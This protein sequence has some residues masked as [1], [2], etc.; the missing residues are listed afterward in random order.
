MTLPEFPTTLDE[1]EVLASR[2]VGVVTAVVS[3]NQDPDGLGRVKVKFPWLGDN[4]ESAWARIATPMAGGQR[5]VYFLP[6]VDDE[7]L[8]AF[9]HGDMR[10]PYVLG[11][12][13]NGKNKPPVSGEQAKGNAVRMIKSRSGH[14]LRLTDE[15]GKEKIEIE[16]GK[17]KL[18]I[19]TAAKTITVTADRDIKLSA[20]QGQITLSAKTIVI[21]AQSKVA[22]QSK[23]EVKS[24]GSAEIDAKAS[25]DLK[26]SGP[27]NLKGSVVNI[28]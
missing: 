3:N 14:V 1:Q 2:I 28:N 22:A 25:L 9:E 13:W 23:I 21:E 5:G 7:V 18:V 6:E 20:P 17:N 12:L 4:V 26:A 8:V 19:D 16:D 11:A 24:S 10:F 27:A 15:K